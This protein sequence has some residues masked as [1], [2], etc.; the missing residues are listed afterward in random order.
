[1]TQIPR[2]DLL[3]VE[4]TQLANERTFLAYFRTAAALLTSGLV[5]SRLEFFEKMRDLSQALLVAAPVFLA[6]GAWR[7]VVVRR[8]VKGIAKVTTAPAP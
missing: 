3:A 5:L 4:R 6:I 2:A 8:R 7:F 1:M